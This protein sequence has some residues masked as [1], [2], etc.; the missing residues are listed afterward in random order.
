MKKIFNLLTKQVTC[1]FALLLLAG[2]TYGQCPAGETNV[3]VCYTAGGFNAENG[4]LLWNATTGAVQLDGGN[5]P[6]EGTMTTCV[7][8]GDV[9]E[10]YVFETFGDGW[11]L[12]ACIDVKTNE[13]G[14]VNGCAAQNEAL[15]TTCPQN[16]ICLL[17][18]SPSPRDGLLSRMPSSA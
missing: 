15:I 18:T 3:D 5:D 10:L 14:L 8:D 4:W 12:P 9:I 1:V 17:Y 6:A 7:T 2:M 13:S 11:C 16:N